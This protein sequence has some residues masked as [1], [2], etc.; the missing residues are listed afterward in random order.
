[1]PQIESVRGGVQTRGTGQPD[2]SRAAAGSSKALLRQQTTGEI[3][4]GSQG[5]VLEVDLLTSSIDNFLV[6]TPT[7]PTKAIRLLL[8]LVSSG[9]AGPR[10]FFRFTATGAE[11]LPLNLTGSR[12]QVINLVGSTI[13]G[14]PGES[15]Y[16]N[17][18]SAVATN[19]TVLYV[20]V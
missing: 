9:A 10:V 7:V 13:Q 11:L 14:N 18:S 16:F 3:A 19:M 5:P 1:M 6:A 20:E 4:M 8:V 17:N 2:Y 12:P 15:L